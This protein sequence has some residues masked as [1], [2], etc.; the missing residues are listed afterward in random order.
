MRAAPQYCGTPGLPHA[1]RPGRARAGGISQGR[2]TERA[3]SSGVPRPLVARAPTARRGQTRVSSSRRPGA[4]DD[5]DR[6]PTEGDPA[7]A[8]NALAGACVLAFFGL[9]AFSTLRQRR[10]TSTERSIGPCFCSV[11]REDGTSSHTPQKLSETVFVSPSS[12]DAGTSPPERRRPEPRAT[13]D[14]KAGGRSTRNPR[15]KGWRKKYWDE[16]LDRVEGDAS[17]GRE[18]GAAPAD[19]P[20]AGPAANDGRWYQPTPPPDDDATPSDPDATRRRRRAERR[21]RPELPPEGD[22]RGLPSARRR[23]ALRCT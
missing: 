11:L 18:D 12:V 4:D 19:D 17:R 2:A 8:P 13:R 10:S 15:F 16:E 9:F 1:L 7:V 23:F 5:D 3:I 14:S 20:W 21:K 6:D 22:G